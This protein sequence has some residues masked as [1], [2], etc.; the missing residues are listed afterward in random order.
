[1]TNY[2]LNWGLNIGPQLVTPYVDPTGKVVTN[3]SQNINYHF[4]TSSPAGGSANLSDYEW[5]TWMCALT[6]NVFGRTFMGD[7]L[8][9]DPG[10]QQLTNVMVVGVQGIFPLVVYIH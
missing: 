8:F 4:Q 9:V 10:P 3:E 1:V 7:V 2:Q 6:F 5:F